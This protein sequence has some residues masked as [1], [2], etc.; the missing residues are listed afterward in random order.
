MKVIIIGCII[1]N[2]IVYGI[3]IKIWLNDC[4]EIGKNNLAVSLLE[5]LRATFLVI[6]LPC[7]VGLLMR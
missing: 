1:F 2:L 4:K 7:V 6:T 3:V 5:R